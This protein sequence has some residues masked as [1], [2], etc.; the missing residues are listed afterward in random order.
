MQIEFQFE[1]A[2]LS[3]FVQK[4]N[5]WI[6][7]ELIEVGKNPA[8]PFNHLLNKKTVHIV[9]LFAI[10]W[11]REGNFLFETFGHKFKMTTG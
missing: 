5:A 4:K 1:L 6:I 3:L 11:S 7:E 8:P 9:D 10:V 2:N